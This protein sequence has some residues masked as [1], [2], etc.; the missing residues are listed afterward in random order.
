MF[1][2]AVSLTIV[3]VLEF[4]ASVY[5]YALQDNITSLLKVKIEYAMQYYETNA[6][7][8]SAIDFLQSKV[9]T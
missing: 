2:F 1:Q 8:K 7:A 3:L 9:Y 5:A 4:T 6:E